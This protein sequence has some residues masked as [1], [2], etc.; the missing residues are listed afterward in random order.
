[1]RRY[2]FCIALTLMFWSGTFAD[3]SQRIS[4]SQVCVG[5]NK[6]VGSLWPMSSVEKEYD[7]KDKS[8]EIEEGVKQL[9]IKRNGIYLQLQYDLRSTAGPKKPAALDVASDGPPEQCKATPVDGPSFSISPVALGESEVQVR[10]VLGEP[11]EIWEPKTSD[12]GILAGE[13]GLVY[14]GPESS[15]VLIVLRNHAVVRV[16]GSV[17]P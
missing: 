6:C 3:A 15:F 13:I 12:H 8:T 16:A 17:L 9:C 4:A 10:K 5:I 7:I 11:D 14:S 1:M 2:L